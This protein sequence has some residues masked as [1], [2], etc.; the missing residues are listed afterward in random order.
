MSRLLYGVHPVL[1]ALAARRREVSAVYT[2]EDAVEKQAR[3]LGVPCER[4]TRPELDAL[5]GPGVRHQGAI[6]VVGE[7]PYATVEAVVAAVTPP[8]VLAL[9]SVTDP[10]NLGALVRSAHMLGAGGV[11]VPKDRA[12]QVTPAVVR[13]SAG[14]SEHTKIASVT[15]LARTLEELKE[16]GLWIVGAVAG[17]AEAPLPWQV[18]FRTPT[19]LVI[20]S[21]STGLRRLVRKICDLSVRI[22]T[23][24]QVGSLSA[25]AAGAVLLY[26]AA[27][28]RKEASP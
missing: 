4:R 19:A 23:L 24:G 13:A 14:A 21:E 11:I 28:Q 16:R 9:D 3:T 5:A 8:L 15:N 6:A 12:A 7:Y 17:G 22:P 2:S 18:D 27:R 25:A 26:E 20:G 1:E 10:Q